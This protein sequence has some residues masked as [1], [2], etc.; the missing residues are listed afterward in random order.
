M[1]AHEH[2]HILRK[3]TGNKGFKHKENII[4]TL[5][6]VITIFYSYVL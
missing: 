6:K 2:R 1:N 4:V 3:Y 5:T